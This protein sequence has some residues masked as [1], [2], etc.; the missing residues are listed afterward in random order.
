MAENPDMSPEERE[1]YRQIYEVA[2]DAF[3]E[4]LSRVEFHD[5]KAQINLVVIGIVLSLGAVRT[6]QIVGLIRQSH[7]GGLIIPLQLALILCA[8]IFFVVSL[9]YSILAL[10]PRDLQAYPSISELM[11]RIPLIPDTQTGAKRTPVPEH[12][13]HPFRAIPDTPSGW[14]DAGDVR[15]FS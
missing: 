13:G 10:K 4:Q 9:F 15:V 14:S 8:F 7:L 12:S 3:L 6:D 5:K 2:R 11:V 1:K